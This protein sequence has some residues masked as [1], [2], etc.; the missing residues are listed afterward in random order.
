[1]LIHIRLVFQDKSSE[2][3]IKDKIGN[4]S[5]ALYLHGISSLEQAIKPLQ[6]LLDVLHLG[7][8]ELMKSLF[9][10]EHYDEFLIYN[11]NSGFL[12]SDKDNL[13]INHQEIFRGVK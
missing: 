12:N 3:I 13:L 10:T 6:L 5:K 8:F 2:I 1:N 4:K 7:T 9:P 11:I